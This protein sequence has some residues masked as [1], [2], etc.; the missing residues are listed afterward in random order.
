MCVGT[1]GAAGN[2]AKGVQG[3]QGSTGIG[4]SAASGGKG[5]GASGQG[6]GQQI[7]NG[8]KFENKPLLSDAATSSVVDEDSGVRRPTGPRDG[9]A[10]SKTAQKRK[11]TTSTSFKQKE[12]NPTALRPVQ[13]TLLG[14]ETIGI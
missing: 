8:P 3:L 5:P 6:G 7:S 4:V 9:T 11:A 2:G 12:K 14:E 10:A 13:T 1:G